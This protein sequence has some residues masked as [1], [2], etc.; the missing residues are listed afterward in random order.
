MKSQLINSKIIIENQYFMNIDCIYQLFKFSNVEIEQ[1]ECYQKMSFRNRCMMAGANGLIQLS[2]PLENGRGQ[3][4]PV[5]DV[6][7]NYAEN[8]QKQHWRTLF[9]CYGNAPFF[10]F[11]RDWL[12]AFYQKEF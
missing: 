1:Y 12:E 10:E 2:V 4:C 7:I 3:K 8:W 5:R 6:R 9:S 11:Y